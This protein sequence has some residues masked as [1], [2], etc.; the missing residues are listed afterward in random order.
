MNTNLKLLYFPDI[1]SLFLYDVILLISS[2]D[3]TIKSILSDVNS[4]GLVF[5]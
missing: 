1:L 4:F 3:I 5:V 2:N